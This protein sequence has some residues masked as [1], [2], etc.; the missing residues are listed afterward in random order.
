MVGLVV[1]TK[2]GLVSK[3]DGTTPLFSSTAPSSSEP[4][5]LSH[6]WIRIE[7]KGD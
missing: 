6:E 4:R 3:H 7:E 2:L 5:I 1:N